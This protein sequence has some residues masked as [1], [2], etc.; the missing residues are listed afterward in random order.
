MKFIKRGSLP[1]ITFVN[2]GYIPVDFEF[3]MVNTLKICSG[4]L[5]WGE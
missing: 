5:D 3:K 2:S 4:F 1:E